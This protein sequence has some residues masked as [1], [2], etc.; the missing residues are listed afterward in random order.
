MGSWGGAPGK[1]LYLSIVQ[2]K[3][4]T[5]LN[6]VSAETGDLPL[7]VIQVLQMSPMLNAAGTIDFAWPLKHLAVFQLK[8]LAQ[9]PA[10]DCGLR[11]P[12]TRSQQ[13]SSFYRQK[14]HRRRQDLPQ[15]WESGKCPQTWSAPAA[16]WAAFLAKKG[17][18]FKWNCR[19]G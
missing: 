11:T 19:G 3:K 16:L 12:A 8:L 17:V 1:V 10:D 6:P 15:C 14:L 13:L 18:D 7:G 4:T 2:Q 9:S 5:W